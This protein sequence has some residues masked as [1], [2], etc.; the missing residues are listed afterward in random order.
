MLIFVFCIF[1]TI[2]F[3]FSLDR[4]FHVNYTIFVASAFFSEISSNVIFTIKFSVSYIF[5]SLRQARQLTAVCGALFEVN[6]QAI[7]R[8]DLVFF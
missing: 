6:W 3:K 4:D 5:I 2:V 1:L 8:A 7:C